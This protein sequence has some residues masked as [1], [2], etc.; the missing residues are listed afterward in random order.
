MQSVEVQTPSKT[1]LSPLVPPS[2]QDGDLQVGQRLYILGGSWRGWLTPGLES[3]GMSPT[4]PA[5]TLL[6]TFVVR[7]FGKAG[8]LEGLL[9]LTGSTL[10][11]AGS[12]NPLS[13]PHLPAAPKRSLHWGPT[14]CYHSPSRLL[15][16]PFIRSSRNF[17][18][19]PHHIE[20][21][22]FLGLCI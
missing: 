21:K 13:P 19:L 1:F 9:L 7:S 14:H 17:W 8:G 22:G 18:L 2:S 4:P 15:V 5:H 20:A 10:S 12:V 11:Q 6:E 3:S 16:S